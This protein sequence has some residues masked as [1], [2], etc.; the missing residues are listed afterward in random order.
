MTRPLAL[1]RLE[2]WRQV[3]TKVAGEIPT[4]VVANKVDLVENLTLEEDKRRAFSEHW[5]VPTADEREDGDGVGDA[6]RGLIDLILKAQFRRKR[7]AGAD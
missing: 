6:F 2:G 1:A 4:Y 5:D 7:Q 3:A